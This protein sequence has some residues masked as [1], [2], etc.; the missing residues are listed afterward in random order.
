MSTERS[1][2]STFRSASAPPKYDRTSKEKG[3][4]VDASILAK[5]PG[6]PFEYDDIDRS[7]PALN[8]KPHPL[9]GAWYGSSLQLNISSFSA[10]Q[11]FTGNCETLL[12]PSQVFGKTEPEIPKRLDGRL[13]VYFQVSAKGYADVL[14]KGRY[15]PD[16]DAIVGEIASYEGYDVDSI[17]NLSFSS[18]PDRCQSVAFTRARPAVTRFKYLL[19]ESPVDPSLSL[20]RR[21]WAFSTQVVLLEA[22]IK[23]GSSKVIRRGMQDRQNWTK[24]LT[25]SGDNDPKQDSIER[26]M[27]YLLPENTRL[28]SGLILYLLKRKTHHL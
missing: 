16:E 6:Q 4:P 1:T 11:R 27:R 9:Q 26:E 24:K 20:A 10:D 28:Y 13:K 23:L 25:R 2:L 12:F 18:E 17:A 7:F 3:N 5:E 14:F 15:D 8:H 19:E 21:R 22:Q